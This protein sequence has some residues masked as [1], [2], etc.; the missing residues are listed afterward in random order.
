MDESREKAILLDSLLAMVAATTPETER[1][2]ALKAFA[3]IEKEV[4]RE[5]E[6]EE[7]L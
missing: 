1:A 3:I 6:E 2:D 5:A 7:S 4:R